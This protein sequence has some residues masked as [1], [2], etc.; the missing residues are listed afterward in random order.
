MKKLWLVVFAL[1]TALAIVPAA[2]ADSFNYAIAGA[3]FSADLTLTTA[4]GTVSVPGPDSLVD[5]NAYIVTFVSGTFDIANGPEETFS[6]TPTAP[7]NEGV[8]AY[9]LTSNYGFLW[10]NLL[11][12]G[13]P[14]NEI[15]DYGG[16]LI[17]FSNGYDLNLFSG[18]FGS[19]APD[20]G[21][22]YFA[23]NGNFDSNNPVTDGNN[24]PAP[25]GLTPAPEP[26]SL[27][28]FGTGL[29]AMALIHYRIA[30]KLK[31]RPVSK[32]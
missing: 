2:Q 27:F 30:G 10:D 16:I 14:G 26:G 3:N 12:P 7:A 5:I 19:G 25:D 13:N 11:Y 24:G 1:A 22:F 20:N 8:N 9:N 6:A 31:A 32:R 23:D 17:A 21:Y 28:L 29:L 15:L 18:S 4:D